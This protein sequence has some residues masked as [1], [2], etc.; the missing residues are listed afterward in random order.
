MIVNQYNRI[1][2]PT[3]ATLCCSLAIHTVRTMNVLSS[4]CL[5]VLDAKE[6]SHRHAINT[7]GSYVLRPFLL[8]MLIPIFVELLKK[9]CTFHPFFK[10]TFFCIS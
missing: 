2:L 1:Y 8:N 5:L 4:Y 9:K 7:L 6:N 3:L 10:Y